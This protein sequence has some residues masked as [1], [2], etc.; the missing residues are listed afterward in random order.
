[1]AKAT[2]NVT[3]ELPE[4][5]VQREAADLLGEFKSSLEAR[6]GTLEAYLA[7]TGTPFE[8]LVEDL[9]PQAANNVKTR[10]VLDAV[11]KAEGLEVSDEDVQSAIGQIAMGS[12]IDPKELEKRLR[13]ND[14]LEEL[15]Q[16]ILRDKAAEVIVDNAVEGP[17][18]AE[19]GAGKKPAAKKASGA[20]AAK[21]VRGSR[22][23][24]GRSARRAGGRRG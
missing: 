19:P 17:P 1:M 11:A 21:E 8:K 3:I 15:K 10:L 23:A 24:G 14:R 9:M 2:E 18:E 22:G 4:V 20:T 7:A 13:K 5:V 12:R 16:Q 6:G